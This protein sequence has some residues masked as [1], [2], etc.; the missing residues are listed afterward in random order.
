MSPNMTLLVASSD[1]LAFNCSGANAEVGMIV[2]LHPKG[3][4]PKNLKEETENKNYKA[5]LLFLATMEKLKLKL[6][7]FSR[8]RA[9]FCLPSDIPERQGMFFLAQNRATSLLPTLN[10]EIPVFYFLKELTPCSQCN[11]SVWIVKETCTKWI[12]K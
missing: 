12:P 11:K 2:H 4:S 10:N 6:R 7:C 3:F 5:I 9:G 8:D 1:H